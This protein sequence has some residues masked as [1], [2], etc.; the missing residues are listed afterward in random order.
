MTTLENKFPLLAVEHGCIIS[1]DADITVA[2]EVELPELYTVTGA[3]YEAIHGCWCKAIKV[4]PDYS[5]VHKQD[6]FIKE[7]YKPEL[8]NDDMSFLSRSFER[9]FNERPYLKHT[10]YLYLTKTTKERNRMQ[11]NFSTLCRG[12]IIPKELDRETATKFMEACEQFERIMNDSG[13]VRLRRLSTDE[14]VGT[15]GKSAG[16]IERYF[17]L[18]PEG[19]TT[20]QDIELSAKEMRIGDNRSDCR[21]SFASPVGLLLSCNH[22]YNQYVIIDNSEETLQKFEKSARN[23]QSLSRYSRSNSINREWIDQYLNEAHSYGLTSVR[24]H[25]NVMAWSDDAEELKH[26]R[27]DV[28]SQLASMECVPRHNTIDCPTLYWA[29]IP[30]NAADFPA[31]ESF[32][33]FIEQAVCLFTEETNYRSFA[34]ALRHQDGGQA[35]GKTAAPRHQRPADEAGYHHQPQQ[36]RAG[37]FGQ[38]QVVL[39]EP[40]RAPIL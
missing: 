8:Q 14:I 17:S 9:H 12:H 24:A 20:L 3:E 38:R 11:S 15:E 19:D 39:H 36:V 22:I 29:A 25:F 1:K 27:N 37:S 35:H 26:I 18:M 28:G 32:H 6:W 21:L 2:F 30:G 33:T 34:L 40:P 16:L 10:C 4:L 23:M 5:V 13:L 7:R 31:E